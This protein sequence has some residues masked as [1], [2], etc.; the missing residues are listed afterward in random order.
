MWRLARWPWLFAAV[1]AVT[2]AITWPPL[3]SGN[4]GL[5]FS[6]VLAISALAGLPSLTEGMR[7]KRTAVVGGR[8]LMVLFVASQIGGRFDFGRMRTA[9]LDFG[10]YY[11]AGKAVRE[12][13]KPLYYIPAYT[14]GRMKFI[15]SVDRQSLSYQL[16]LQEGIAET[17][18]LIYPPFAAMLFEPFTFVPF[19]AALAIWTGITAFSLLGSIFVILVL[20]GR[21]NRLAIF[22]A[23]VIGV[24]SLSPVRSTFYL[25]QVNALLLFFWTMG[26][27]LY[28]KQKPES[29]ALCFA[30][31]AMIKVTPLMVVPLFVLTR[32]WRWLAAFGVWLVLLLVVAM[33][34][35]GWGNLHL[36]I[37]QVLPSMSC[38]APHFD[39]CSVGA[40]VQYWY[41][42]WVPMVYEVPETLPSSVCLMAKLVTTFTYL[43]MLWVLFRV[44]RRRGLTDALILI[45]LVSLLVS[46]VT[47]THHYVLAVLPLL[48]LW[49]ARV[50]GESRELLYAAVFATVLIGTNAAIYTLTWVRNAGIDLL[51]VALQPLS[52]ALL[53]VLYA[54]PHRQLTGAFEPS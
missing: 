25:G 53:V 38:G 5:L 9:G 35:T 2:N 23:A 33:A 7:A 4:G 47:W 36:Y 29:S 41:L 18:P 43:I 48:Y 50:Q 54:Y 6:I 26:V 27:Y 34:G 42:R 30:L 20:A 16:A 21:E 28:K 15:P 19:P 40:M 39:N 24:F 17:M 11:R 51:L 49:V 52:V 46:P 1:I 10:V 45:A 44:L 8:I 14:D 12:P 37:S 32:S 31:G 22:I 13:G 3:L